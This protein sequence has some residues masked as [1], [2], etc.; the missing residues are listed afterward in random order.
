MQNSYLLKWSKWQFRGLQNDQNWFHIKSGY[1]AGKSGHFHTVVVW[2]WISTYPCII[3]IGWH[4]IIYRF[5]VNPRPR[6][7]N[8][9]S[10]N[11]QNITTIGGNCGNVM[12]IPTSLILSEILINDGRRFNFKFHVLPNTSHG[13]IR[14][15]LFCRAGLHNQSD[16]PHGGGISRKG[17]EVTFHV[18]SSDL[19]KFLMMRT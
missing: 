7:A 13:L 19:T 3:L 8:V 10:G 17:S 2:F 15:D 1:V 12:V 4:G 14:I 9:G 5:N 18:K 16:N 11:V 6:H